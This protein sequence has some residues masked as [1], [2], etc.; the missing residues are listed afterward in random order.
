[1]K[2]HF[3]EVIQLRKIK[4]AGE[5]ATYNIVP[6]EAPSFTNAIGVFPEASFPLTLCLLITLKMQ[7]VVEPFRFGIFLRSKVLNF[8]TPAWFQAIRLTS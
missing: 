4:K 6:L 8:F 3:Y 5:L 7:I 2:A 1:M